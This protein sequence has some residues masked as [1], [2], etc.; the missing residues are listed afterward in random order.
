MSLPEADAD[1]TYV[2]VWLPRAA[3]IRR[4]Q[5]THYYDMNEPERGW[6]CLS[7]LQA[8]V[9]I[10]RAP[11]RIVEVLHGFT[12]VRVKQYKICVA[13]YIHRHQ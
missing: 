1:Y 7:E 4:A 3:A 9:V 12:S 10:N 11:S 8:T 6:T 2:A 5:M 13:K